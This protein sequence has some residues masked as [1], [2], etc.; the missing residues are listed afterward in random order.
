MFSGSQLT[1]IDRRVPVFG[2][3][4]LGS[5]QF[6]HRLKATARQEE[7][8]TQDSVGGSHLVPTWPVVRYTV[9][10]ELY[11]LSNPCFPHVNM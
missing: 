4:Y 9:F 11:S 3:R 5:K 1:T 7:A 10:L 6:K 8:Q 2:Y